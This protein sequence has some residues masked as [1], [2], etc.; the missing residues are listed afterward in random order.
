[1]DHVQITMLTVNRLHTSTNILP[2]NQM[3]QASYTDS[4]Y[5]LRAS[6]SPSPRRRIRLPQTTKALDRTNPMSSN[7][8]LTTT[9]TQ[10]L[11]AFGQ[12]RSKL[13]LVLRRAQQQNRE[14]ETHWQ[15]PTALLQRHRLTMGAMDIRRMPTTSL[16]K[17]SLRTLIRTTTKIQKHTN[18]IRP[19]SSYTITLPCTNVVAARSHS[20]LAT[21]SSST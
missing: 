11:K 3:A 7:P 17:P 12:V 8:T 5:Y 21:S 13:T 1:M 10:L 2:T 6:L 9:H 18:K 14:Q 4:N 19:H 16:R 15:S 20:H